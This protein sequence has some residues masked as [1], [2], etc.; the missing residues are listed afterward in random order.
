MVHILLHSAKCIQFLKPMSSMYISALTLLPLRIQSLPSFFAYVRI[1]C[2]SL[3]RNS[4]G[5]SKNH[6]GSCNLYIEFYPVQNKVD[7]IPSR[8]GLSEN[9]RIVRHRE[10]T[11][12]NR[13]HK[14]AVE[15]DDKSMQPYRSVR[16]HFLI[17]ACGR[18]CNT[19][20]DINRSAC[21]YTS[22]PQMTNATQ[23]H[24]L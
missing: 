7:F 4:K 1:P 19:S 10:I 20:T 8:H 12:Y 22:M 13:N 3:K 2:K 15:K 21:T 11:E 24:I 6:C 18:C 17:S 9:T 23:N 16:S 14:H 5:P